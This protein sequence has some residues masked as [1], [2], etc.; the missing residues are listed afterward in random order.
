MQCPTFALG[1]IENSHTFQLLGALAADREGPQ[2]GAAHSVSCVERSPM[3][4]AGV[5]TVSVD[6]NPC[7]NL[8]DTAP[9]SLKQRAGGILLLTLAGVLVN[10]HDP[11]HRPRR[12]EPSQRHSE[13][14]EPGRR[15]PPP[16]P[17]LDPDLIVNAIL[18][19][20]ARLHE[21]AELEDTRE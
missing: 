6:S 1:K 18:I 17:A 2:E 3:L 19:D 10:I 7:A 13:Y 8:L 21:S 20:H 11:Y 5:L 14:A 4:N 16:R 15:P 12:E 9:Q